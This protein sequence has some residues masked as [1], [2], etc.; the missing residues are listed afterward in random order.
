MSHDKHQPFSRCVK[1]MAERVVSL[2]TTER[3]A[4]PPPAFTASLQPVKE[5]DVG[6]TC[7]FVAPPRE[8]RTECPICLHILREPHQA[9]CCGTIFC[10]LCIERVRTYKKPCPTCRERNFGVFPDRGLQNSLYSFKVQCPSK[11][12]GCDWEGELRHLDG[13]LN[14]N[15]QGQQRFLGCEF[16]EKECSMCFN[17]FPRGILEMHEMKKCPSRPYTCEYCSNYNSTFE[18]VVQKH[19]LECPYR[20]VPCTNECGVYPLRKD[21]QYHLEHEC[22]LRDTR[23]GE[24]SLKEIQ[25]L[26]ETTIKAQLPS[27]TADMLKKT[28]QKEIGQEMKVLAE[29]NKELESL[30]AIR[31]ESQSLRCEIEQLKTQIEEDHASIAVLKSHLSIV[32]VTFTLDD[33]ENRRFRQEMG[34]TSPFFYTHPRGYHMSLLVD[35][36]GSDRTSISVYF[37]FV[38]GDYD[39]QLKWPFR[40]SITMQ[41]INQKDE[42][43]H[44]VEVVRYH[45]KTPDA[46]AG[47]VFEDTR[48]SKPWG[49]VKFI[50]YQALLASGEFVVNDTLVFQVTKVVLD[51]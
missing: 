15:S 10:R 16:V 29:L 26:I 18:D 14:T 46:S 24:I 33:F 38:K 36:G 43:M 32:P 4:L 42:N 31:V 12:Q 35:V 25:K 13:H 44:H 1:E 19:W 3:E 30:K 7:T 23:S 20:S 8:L 11:N 49:K 2:P 40:G 9:T 47:R 51:V 48:A 17:L 21:L 22:D 27:M 34:W 28:I 39:S 5:F 50:S 37:N 6:F 41:L 45:A